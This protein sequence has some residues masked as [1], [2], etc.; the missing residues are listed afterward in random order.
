M[1]ASLSQLYF[2]LKKKSD[3][4]TLEISTHTSKEQLLEDFRELKKNTGKL[5]S[6]KMN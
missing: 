6:K 4:E 2:R 5:L 3:S 1:F